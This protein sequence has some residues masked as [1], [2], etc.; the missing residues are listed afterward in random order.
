M[1]DAPYIL[2][3]QLFRFGRQGEAVTKDT[4][5]MMGLQGVVYVP[6]YTGLNTLQQVLNPYQVAAAQHHF[7]ETPLTGHYRSLLS[8][9]V[10][11]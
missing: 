2:C 7:G 11:A 6:I 1:C 5:P 9:I 10:C 3:L 8:K 4:R